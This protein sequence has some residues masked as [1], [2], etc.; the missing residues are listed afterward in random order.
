M[1]DNYLRVLPK[2]PMFIP[3]VAQASAG[4]RTFTELAPQSAEIRIR[5]EEE[6]TFVDAGANFSAVR[7]PTCA[8]DLEIVPWWQ[9]EM[10]HAYESRFKDLRVVPPCCAQPTTLNE[11]I[12][13][14]PQG[15][16]RWWLEALNPHRGKLHPDELATVATSVGCSLREVWTHV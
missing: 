8:A 3:S 12:Y 9:S 5:Y 15:F 6:V 11:L 4:L 10:D 1:S 14:W 13:D 7:C 2:D 16:A